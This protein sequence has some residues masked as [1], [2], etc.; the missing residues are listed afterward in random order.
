MALLT[1]KPRRHGFTLI[2]VLVVMAILG[3]LTAVLLPVIWKARDAGRS[4][5][6]ASNLK[7]IGLALSLYTQD[8]NTRYP[9]A[10]SSAVVGGVAR[11][12]RPWRELIQP[13]LSERRGG[14]DAIA[15]PE[16]EPVGNLEAAREGVGG[17]AINM[18]LNNATGTA[19]SYSLAGRSD[20]RVRFPSRTVTACDARAGII[21]IGGPDTSDVGRA[22]GVLILNGHDADIVAQAPAGDRHNGGANY[23]FADGHVKWLRPDQF[24]SPRPSRPSSKHFGFGL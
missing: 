1:M 15:C 12:T 17:Y 4:A 21:A 10:I 13:Y 16:A 8:N 24:N 2:E 7:Q 11:R 6:C 18:L 3:L 20:V 5:A 22:V 23:A 19:Q 14:S 9:P